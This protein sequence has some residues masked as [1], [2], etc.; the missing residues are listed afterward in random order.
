M[1]IK[2]S[3][4]FDELQNEV[5]NW[6][7]NNG[8]YNGSPAGHALRMLREVVEL[9]IAAGAQ[10]KDI[11]TTVSDELKKEMTENFEHIGRVNISTLPYEVADV[12]LLLMV[13][14]GYQQV[15]IMKLSKHKFEIVLER[16]WQV[17]SQGV[18]WRPGRRPT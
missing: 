17:D 1:G 6:H 10:P 14:A 7:K 11:T 4:E 8:G 9:C 13:F 15:D 18:L 16:K 12:Q 3:Q 5:M 2:K